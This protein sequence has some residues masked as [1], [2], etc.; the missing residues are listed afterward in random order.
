MGFNANGFV[1]HPHHGFDLRHNLLMASPLRTPLADDTPLDVEIRQVALWQRMSRD[2]KAAL[3]TGLCRAVHEAATEGIQRR[4]PDATPREQFLR[5]AI[6][7][8]GRD[9]CSQAFPDAA[10]LQE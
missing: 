7:R 6:L 2:E 8:L 3:V 9:L 1:A 5:L 10:D 4:Y